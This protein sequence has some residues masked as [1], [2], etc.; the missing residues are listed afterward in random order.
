MGA[1]LFGNKK[2]KKEWCLVPFKKLRNC[3]HEIT[4][5]L[6]KLQS[7]KELFQIV[8]KFDWRK[9]VSGI[10]GAV[11]I[12]I[13]AC[14]LIKYPE[15]YVVYRTECSDLT[16]NRNYYEEGNTEYKDFKQMKPFKLGE[17]IEYFSGNI[18]K[19]E[20][21]RNQVMGGFFGFGIMYIGYGLLEQKTK[22]R[23]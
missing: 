8:M 18:V 14:A 15:G 22:R 21:I 11:L 1:L 12:S 10:A 2:G 5:C 16:K 17:E 20:K 4:I 13:A 3:N 19:M 9:C 7:I 6:K 23:K